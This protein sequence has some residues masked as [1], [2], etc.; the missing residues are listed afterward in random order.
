MDLKE[1]RERAKR[2]AGPSPPTDTITPEELKR[3][4]NP[5]AAP[6]RTPR[7][8]IIYAKALAK[9]KQGYGK[10]PLFRRAPF[11]CPRCGGLPW[12]RMRD[13]SDSVIACI[14]P[15]CGWTSTYTNKTALPRA[16]HQPDLPKGSP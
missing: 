10:H 16:P 4:T 5:F 8:Q 1:F 6:R 9:P 11:N 12:V 2:I 13:H 14:C 3:R 15:D 7:Q